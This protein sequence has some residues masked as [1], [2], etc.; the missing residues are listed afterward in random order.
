M[1][2]GNTEAFHPLLIRPTANVLGKL[3]YVRAA[4]SCKPTSLTTALDLFIW[5][6]PPSSNTI[7]SSA[8]TAPG[9]K[10]TV[11]ATTPGSFTQWVP[12][13]R[14]KSA[15]KPERCRQSPSNQDNQLQS[16]PDAII[17]LWTTLS[18]LTTRRMWK[19][20]TPGSTGRCLCHNFST[21]TTTH[22]L[23]L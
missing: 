3:S 23:Q 14:T 7:T 16:R 5:G 1:A 6:A 21:T 20:S 19:L 11:W 10:S 8:L 2:I 18:L 9:R 13:P 4:P 17:P 12:S 15:P 22:N